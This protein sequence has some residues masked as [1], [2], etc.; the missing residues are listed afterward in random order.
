[1]GLRRPRLR[2]HGSDEAVQMQ[3]WENPEDPEYYRARGEVPEGEEEEEEPLEWI[4]A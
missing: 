2:R 4:C 3:P 1:M